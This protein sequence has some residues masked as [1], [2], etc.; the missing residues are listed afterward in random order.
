MF[1]S[2]LQALPEIT[3]GK[4]HCPMDFDKVWPIFDSAQSRDFR[5]VVQSIISELESQGALPKSNSRVSS[6]ASCYMLWTDVGC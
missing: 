6:L 4:L 2:Q 3:Y 5:K 1:V